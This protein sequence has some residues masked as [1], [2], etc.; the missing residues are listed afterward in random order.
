MAKQSTPP[1]IRPSLE[2]E[3]AHTHL[4]KQLQSLQTFKGR[5]CKEA[6]Y[7]EQQWMQLT[8]GI[9]EKAFG[10]P[11]TASDN[12]RRAR[13]AGNYSFIAGRGIPSVSCHLENAAG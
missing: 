2:P 11:S 4:K 1:P 5:D 7:D 9:V 12:F 8:E 6:E 10:K 3:R 13:M